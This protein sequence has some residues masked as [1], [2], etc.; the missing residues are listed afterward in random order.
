[1]DRKQ[2]TQIKHHWFINYKT[3]V[4]HMGEYYLL[5]IFL[6]MYISSYTRV[7]LI[8]PRFDCPYQ[9]KAKH[10][11]VLTGLIFGIY[12]WFRSGMDTK[13]KHVDSLNLFND[14]LL[15]TVSSVSVLQPS[16][17]FYLSKWRGSIRG[18]FIY[19][20]RSR[21]YNHYPRQDCP[22]GIKENNLAVV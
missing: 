18:V 2:F 6:T 7:V 19:R 14:T 4:Q 21:V 3:N 12:N 17:T 20:R 1:M 22:M 9:P 10:A 5:Y 8:W 13:Q 11:R 15:I 16:T